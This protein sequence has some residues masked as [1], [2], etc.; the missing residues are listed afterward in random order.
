MEEQNL[1]DSDLF[2]EEMVLYDHS[3]NITLPLQIY[4]T[5]YHEPCAKE[6]L[7]SLYS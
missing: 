2:D 5:G 1:E 4:G 3:E 7:E 6:S